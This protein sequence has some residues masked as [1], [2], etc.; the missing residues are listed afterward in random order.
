MRLFERLKG[1]PVTWGQRS[2]LGFL[3][4]MVLQAMLSA[5]A[6][7]AAETGTLRIPSTTVTLPS[8]LTA[9]LSAKHKLPMASISVR[10][11]AGSVDDPEDKAGL[12]AMTMR[13]LDKGTRHLTAS[14]IA[15]E[16][17]FLGA[18]LEANAGWT[19]ST[20][21]LAV[22]AK[23]VD[24]GLALLADLLQH[25]HFDAEEL[26]RERAQLLSEIH[27]QRADPD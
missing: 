5:G 17:D 11:K 14:A 7:V 23:D 24:R 25:A 9:V 13:L 8:G 27:Q 10:I 15:D 18:H 20:I 2:A 26:E 12:A 6:A 4:L 19:G 3:H 16:L 1:E 22:L 21:S